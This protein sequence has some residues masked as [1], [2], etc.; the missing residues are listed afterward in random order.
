MDEGAL[1][2]DENLRKAVLY[3]I[4]QEDYI[5]YNNGLVGNLYSSYST[6]IKTDN[7]LVQDLEKS[8]EY[9]KAYHEANAQ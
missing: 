9:L 6:I 3:A 2:T 1:F 5:A 8:A 4:N 7:K